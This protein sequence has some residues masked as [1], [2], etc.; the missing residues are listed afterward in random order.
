MNSFRKY[1]TGVWW[2]MAW[3][4][5]RHW[6]GHSDP[7]WRQIS[8]STLARVVA[9]CMPAQTITWTNVD[10]SF[11][12]TRWHS[13]EGPVSRKLPSPGDRSVLGFNSTELTNNHMQQACDYCY[14]CWITT[15]Y[16]Y[17]YIMHSEHSIV[18]PDFI[19]SIF[20]F[21]SRNTESL[22]WQTC[23]RCLCISL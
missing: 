7:I 19:D 16:I 21:A 14:I 10:L 18:I 15:I 4:I 22:Y 9:C 6:L 3:Q 5:W 8:G 12:E 2:Q 20:Y 23:H 11:F 13:A 17:I 1:E